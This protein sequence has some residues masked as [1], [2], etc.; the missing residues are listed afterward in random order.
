MN[1]TDLVYNQ[2]I[3]HLSYQ[4]RIILV[5]KILRDFISEQKKGKQNRMDELKILQKFKGIAKNSNQIIN[6][7]DWYKQ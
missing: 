5:Q 4:E 3:R 7:D 1:N 6:D 2:Y